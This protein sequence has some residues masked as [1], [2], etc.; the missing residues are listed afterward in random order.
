MRYL[1]DANTPY[2]QVVA[3]RDLVDH[4][5]YP[6]QTLQSKA[7]DCDDLTVLYAS[8][9]EAAG[10]A[11]ALVDFPGH[12]FLL[13]DSGILRRQAYQLP[14]DRQLYVVR[15]EKLWIPVE[16]TQLDRTFHQAWQTGLEEMAELA[17]LG[18]KPWM[19]DTA[20]AWK[21]YPPANLLWGRGA[22]SPPP[23]AYKDFLEAEYRRLQQA[24]NDYLEKQYLRPLAADPE[25]ISLR[26]KLGKIYLLMRQYDTAIN[27]AYRHLRS[28][29]GAK[30]PTYNFLGLAHYFKGEWEQ[31]AY[32]FQQALDL[33]PDDMGIQRNLVRVQV[34]LGE[35]EGREG[36]IAT[37]ADRAVGAKSRLAVD[38]LDSFY[39]GE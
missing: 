36:S 5:Q 30:A 16:I 15:G 33:D 7:G 24:M 31:A 18:R 38:D 25:D 19:V 28:S 34:K 26:M 9:L 27:S 8:L 2:N 12:I 4:I 10:I 23:T 14:L 11:T 17:D 35:V 29:T 37:I 39:W 6:A 3:N 13:F 22:D 20:Q 32:F 1:A 21:D